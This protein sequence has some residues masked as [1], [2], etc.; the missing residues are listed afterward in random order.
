MHNLNLVFFFLKF[1]LIL[2]CVGFNILTKYNTSLEFLKEKL[3]E[4]LFLKYNT[5]FKIIFD[6]HNLHLI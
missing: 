3:I 5:L 6:F 2:S 4:L 1:N